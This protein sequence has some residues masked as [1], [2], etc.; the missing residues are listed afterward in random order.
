MGQKARRKAEWKAKGGWVSERTS[1]NRHLP[2]L[3]DSLHLVC[4]EMVPFKKVRFRILFLRCTFGA[5]PSGRF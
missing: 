5:G 1:Y 2:C 3:K 4:D